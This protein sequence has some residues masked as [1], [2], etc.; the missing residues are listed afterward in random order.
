M[1]QA[2]LQQF[3]QN[4]KAKMP[5]PLA[6]LP[7]GQYLSFAAAKRAAVGAVVSVDTYTV[8]SAALAYI[9]GLLA[10]RRIPEWIKEDVSIRNLLPKD[11][12]KSETTSLELST[13]A[14]VIEKLQAL[15]ES[16][17]EK[18]VSIPV[19]FLH[20]AILAYIQLAAHLH[21]LY[22]DDR[23]IWYSSC[24]AVATAGNFENIHQD[25]SAFEFCE[26]VSLSKCLEYAT[27]S[28]ESDTTK[29]REVLG[30]DFTIVQHNTLIK[31]VVRPGN[32]GHY[33]AIS[34][35]MKLIVVGIRGTSSFEELLT[36]C[37]GQA[38]SYNGRDDYANANYDDMF[39]S[40]VEVRAEIPNE[41]VASQ[42]GHVEVISGHEQ[43]WMETH[44]DDNGNDI[45]CHQGILICAIR[46]VNTIQTF[47]K[48]HV[49]DDEYR[50]LLCGHSLGAGVASLSAVVLRSRLPMLTDT[51]IAQKMKVVA[52]A[53]P[54]ILDHDSAVASSSYTTTI[55]NNS[56]IIPRS[57]MANLAIFLEFL[58]EVSSRLQEKGLAPT[59]P[60]TAAAFI[61]K[62]T[63]EVVSNDDLLMTLEEVQ[64]AM[65]KAHHCIELRNPDHLYIPG[66]VLVMFEKWGST[67]GFA[68]DKPFDPEGKWRFVET[69]GSAAMLR[70][71]EIDALRMLTDHGTASYSK[72]LQVFFTK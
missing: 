66:R 47:V 11:R 39:H 58:R 56:D 70:F 27:L 40:R 55:V 25:D 23:D 18:L 54:P 60:I 13:L 3:L 41:L 38:V 57:S 52:F 67:T 37:C 20:A 69:N 72:S 36:D 10:W 15:L 7:I 26:Q 16:G 29:V 14:S 59:N 48:S 46:L 49:V 51:K 35:K 42:D 28:Y 8:S 12:N 64:T 43:V 31:D 71:L 32:V 1:V 30:S 19:P 4:F 2:T 45:R 24:G 44:N 62:M 63:T 53:P 9:L 21:K 68:E 5:P 17:S 50:L 34:K 22:P 33:L 61:S 65:E 6:L